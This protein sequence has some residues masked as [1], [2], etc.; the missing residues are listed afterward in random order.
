MHERSK[1]SEDVLGF[2]C[3]CYHIAGVETVYYEYYFGAFAVFLLSASAGR[4]NV[5]AELVISRSQKVYELK[6]I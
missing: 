5:V 6:G 4:L 2:R 3:C 1:L